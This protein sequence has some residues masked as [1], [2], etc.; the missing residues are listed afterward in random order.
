MALNKN[1]TQVLNLVPHLKKVIDV[2]SPPPSKPRK[3]EYL[4]NF[5]RKYMDPTHVV[6]APGIQMIDEFCQPAGMFNG[7]LFSPNFLSNS[8]ST[9]FLF[10]NFST[11]NP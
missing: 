11:T 7:Y 3:P 9:Y 5:L 6:N 4:H 10:L 8:V 1:G 2:T